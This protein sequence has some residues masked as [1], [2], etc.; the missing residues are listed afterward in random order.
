VFTAESV[1]PEVLLFSVTPVTFVPITA[2]IVVVPAPVP[3]FVIVPPLFRLVVEAVIAPPPL[4]L[5]IRLPVPVTPP[6]SVTVPKPLLV[7][8]VPPL[9][10]L[11]APLITSAEEE[12]SSVIPVTFEPIAALIMVVPVPLPPLVIVPTLFR[13]VVLKVIVPLVPLKIN[14]L[15]VP[16]TPPVK[17]VE[18]A[19]PVVPTVSVPVLLL[20]ST[21]ALAMV[22]PVVLT[23]KLAAVLPP[24]IPSATLPEPSAEPELATV[25]RPPAMVVVPEYP[26]LLP[27][28]VSA[29][30]V[31]VRPLALVPVIAPL[32]VPL[33][34]LKV[35][36][37]APSA[38][39]PAPLKVL[40][41]APLVV[42]LISNVPASAT[43]LLLAIEP[44]PD[45]LKVPAV[46]VV[47]P[48]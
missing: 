29:P 23:N 8:V 26:L 2:L 25:N 22:R 44:E 13:L 15:L 36:V 11:S 45:K 38:K 20:A 31:S 34:L 40:I 32:Y 3:E 39:T 43:P 47:A 10:T 24:L 37:F 21:I 12:R 17:V 6:E 7:T 27:D 16:V 41:V 48:V 35:S 28:K 5:K 19:V 33:A 30:A 9:F 46:I 42:L 1:N 4:A 14:R 18:S